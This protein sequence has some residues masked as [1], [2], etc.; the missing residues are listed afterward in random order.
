MKFNV[1]CRVFLAIL[2]ANAIIV[3]CMFLIMQRSMDRGFLKYVNQLEQN[4]MDRLVDKLER[5]YSSSEQW[6][7]LKNN[8]DAV[9]R[10][11]SETYAEDPTQ[12]PSSRV[13]N[14]APR[15]LL[16]QPE[17]S[18]RRRYFRL[19]KRI[20]LLDAKRS[21]VFGS[22]SP[23]DIDIFKPI[24]VKGEVV[25]Y[26]GLL[27]N[28]FLSDM[29]QLRFVKEQ[30][31]IFAL[32]A[33]LMLLVASAISLPL[34]RLL[35]RPLKKL[36]AATSHLSSGRYDV[37]VPVDSDDEFGHLSRDFNALALSLDKNEQARRQ[38]VADISHELRT[39]L[40][41]LGGE[42]EAIQDGIQDLS[43][44]SISSLH[45]EV[46]R[47]N[48]LVDDLY[49][50]ALSDVGAL[51]YRKYVVNLKDLLSDAIDRARP[52]LAERS[53]TLSAILPQGPVFVFADAERLAQLFDNLVDN[54][55]KY[56]DSGGTLEITLESGCREATI[57]IR[58]SGPGVAEEELRKLFDRLYRVEGSR[59]RSSGGAG[60][61]LA[62]CRNI[63][64]AHEGAIE[65]LKSP[66]GGIW[67]R[68]TLPL[69]GADNE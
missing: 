55:Q 24:S 69:T 12:Q 6:D 28:K 43:L 32:V 21:P 18:R 4:R 10:L 5:S 49:Q 45:V 62:I 66:L 22:G 56:T 40:A 44:E 46:F 13:A 27:P 68:I 25:G 23:A 51:A 7:T 14:N 65:A 48:R 17:P 59:N 50:L 37:R 19:E 54:S 31:T 39:P 11:L 26:L 29:H 33:L 1:T 30:K 2:A 9:S 8:P 16:N 58:D 15:E 38:F 47:L 57:D 34:A 60:L 35:V 61:G 3:L 41:I 64:E 36:A 53:L 67:I 42:I 20:V 52:R 63:V